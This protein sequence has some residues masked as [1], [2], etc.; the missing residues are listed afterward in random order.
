MLGAL[1]GLALM[2]VVVLRWWRLTDGVA[3]GGAMGAFAYVDMGCLCWCAARMFG[4]RL[5]WQ[6]TL[7]FWMP[8][9]MSGDLRLLEV[10]E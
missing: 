8:I 1:A 7:V 5:S 3:V 4:C 6:L 9:F 2:V 10:D